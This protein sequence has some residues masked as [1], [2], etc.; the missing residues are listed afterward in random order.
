MTNWMLQCR[1]PK[2]ASDDAVASIGVSWYELVLSFMKYTGMFFPLRRH[3]NQGREIL[4]PFRSRQEVDAYGVKFSEFANTF[5][6]FYLQFTGLLSEDLWPC[7]ERKLVK[8]MFVQGASIFTSGFAQR[9]VF[10][11]Q[12]WVFGVL[13]PF[14]HEHKGQAISELP[15]LEWV[16][17]E[18]LYKELQ[19]DMKGD[20]KVRAMKTRK[21]MKD[22]RNWRANPIQPLFFGSAAWRQGSKNIPPRRGGDWH[23]LTRRAVASLLRVKG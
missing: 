7:Y 10:P 8:S 11:H 14:L 22:M 5:A 17:P 19:T 16:I 23:S 1:W 13:Q 6:I 4:I 12:D 20:W 9:P 2:E 18:R 21:K 15:A 3:D